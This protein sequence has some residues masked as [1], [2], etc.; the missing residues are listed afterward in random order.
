MVLYNLDFCGINLVNGDT[1][2]KFLKDFLANF[3]RKGRSKSMKLFLESIQLAPTKN[4]KVQV[5]RSLVVSG[6][7]F[8]V[9]F[10]A[11]V[12]FKEVLGVHY[13]VAAT[14]GFGLGVVVNYVLSVRWVF[15]DRKFSDHRAEF[16]IFLI[17]CAVGLGLNLLIIAGMVQ[18]LGADYRVA[19]VV[20][21]VVVFFWNFIARKRILY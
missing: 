17:I 8:I 2:I 11:L 16:V 4:V 13:L 5:I 12:F 19:K 9:D 6:V 3:Y 18:L 7:A 15:A 14:L 1:F 21:T 10:S 20:S